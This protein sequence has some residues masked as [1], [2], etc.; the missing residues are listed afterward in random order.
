MDRCIA[1]CYDLEMVFRWIDI[2]DIMCTLLN[3][4]PYC[5]RRQG[6]ALE[7]GRLHV[8]LQCSIRLVIDQPVQKL[9]GVV[10]ATIETVSLQQKSVSWSLPNA[11]A[12]R[13]APRSDLVANYR[14]IYVSVS[15]NL[16]LA[17][18]V[19]QT[20]LVGSMGAGALCDTVSIAFSFS[21]AQNIMA[22]KECRSNDIR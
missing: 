20:I 7:K 21:V 8:K 13:S 12:T 16:T 19:Y 18:R 6:I 9:V 2:K 4:L 15:L 17:P 5:A 10:A 1:C 11:K 22:T 14:L 3:F